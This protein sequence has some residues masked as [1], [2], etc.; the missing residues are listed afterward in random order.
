MLGVTTHR[1]GESRFINNQ[2]S[3]KT[4]QQN[5]TKD[6][7]CLVAMKNIRVNTKRRIETPT[8]NVP[9]YCSKNIILRI[10]RSLYSMKPN[11]KNIENSWLQHE[12]SFWGQN[13]SFHVFLCCWFQG[14]GYII[15]HPFKWLQWRWLFFSYGWSVLLVWMVRIRYIMHI[16]IQKWLRWFLYVHKQYTYMFLWNWTSDDD[17]FINSTCMDSGLVVLPFFPKKKCVPTQT[18]PPKPPQYPL[19]DSSTWHRHLLHSHKSPNPSCSWSQSLA[20]S[21][22]RK[23]SGA[24]FSRDVMLW[25]R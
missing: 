8:S 22:G 4:W 1:H 21:P 7:G 12:V 25:K 9:P 20:T 19:A 10:Q 15:P 24:I 2:W 18:P 13:A 16:F 5:S 17:T 6:G 11:S 23:T 14:S 3:K